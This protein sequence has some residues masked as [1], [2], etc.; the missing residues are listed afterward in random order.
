MA[1]PQKENGYTPVANEI[2]EQL[3]RQNLNGTQFRIIMVV[4]RFTYGFSRREHEL[5][6]TFISKAI[7]TH[8]KQV[9]RE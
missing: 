6:E 1:N 7:G 9:S 8:K 2:L 3:Y 4:W 5:S